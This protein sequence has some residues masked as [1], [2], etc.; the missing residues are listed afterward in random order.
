MSERPDTLSLRQQYRHYYMASMVANILEDREI[1]RELLGRLQD[2]W[3]R[4]S[5]DDIEWTETER[6]DFQDE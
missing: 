1:E 6:F 5:K 3:R 2:I 4:M